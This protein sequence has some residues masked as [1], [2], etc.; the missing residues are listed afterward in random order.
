[1]K[2]C[3]L[4]CFLFLG[5]G[6]LE[7]GRVGNAT[8]DR[9]DFTNPDV[10]KM[11][12]LKRDVSSIE[13]EELV[14]DTIKINFDSIQFQKEKRS[15]AWRALDNKELIDSL[16]SLDLEENWS[17]IQESEKLFGTEIGKYYENNIP[18]SIYLKLFP[19][20]KIH[21][22]K[23]FVNDRKIDDAQQKIY[24]REGTIVEEERKYKYL[25]SLKDRG[26]ILMMIFSVQGKYA[27]DLELITVSKSDFT[28]IDQL[29]LYGGIY[30]SYDIDYWYAEFL[31]EFRQ[32][33][34]TKVKNLE[35]N[36]VRLDTTT[37]IYNINPNGIIALIE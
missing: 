13:K 3:I 29:K 35:F 15:R 20:E 23:K 27:P 31:D 7:T 9:G 2:N 33:K 12:S 14:Y 4:L 5:C 28:I 16:K 8:I 11:D 30:D 19:N 34:I 10:K 32:V 17:V 6:N 25:Y 18:K 26:E 37:L 36:S 22:R 21:I 1:M 24:L